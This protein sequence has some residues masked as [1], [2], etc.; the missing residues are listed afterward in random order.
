MQ[1]PINRNIINENDKEGNP[2]WIDSY[3]GNKRHIKVFDKET[4]LTTVEIV[5]EE[6]QEFDLMKY[7]KA[8]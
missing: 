7:I 6:E 1:K 5:L 3:H 4:L 2:Y 8:I